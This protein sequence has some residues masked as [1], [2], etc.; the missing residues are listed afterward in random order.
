MN[1]PLVQLQALHDWE[2]HEA[3][4]GAIIAYFSGIPVG[5]D[6]RWKPVDPA[7]WANHPLWV[8]IGVWWKDERDRLNAI[9][10]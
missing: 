2:R 3:V 7:P 9:L 5:S 6:G 10:G 1:N 4:R 8:A